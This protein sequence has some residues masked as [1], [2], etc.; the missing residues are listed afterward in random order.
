MCRVRNVRLANDADPYRSLARQ[1]STLSWRQVNRPPNN[2]VEQMPKTCEA[3]T[4]GLPHN[5]HLPPFRMPH[6]R[7]LDKLG[8]DMDIALYLN[9][10][11]FSDISKIISFHPM[12][13][14]IM[15]SH[16]RK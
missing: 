13:L 2:A 1:A 11:T 7:R 6:R 3:V 4:D 9:E 14:S 10:T 16:V 15:L 5:A 8:R 12:S